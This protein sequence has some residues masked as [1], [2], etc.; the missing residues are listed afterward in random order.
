MN[1]H[2]KTGVVTIPK[3]LD[4]IS[5]NEN[6]QLALAA[7]NLNGKTWDGVIAVFNDAH[8]APNIP[9]IDNGSLNESGCTAIDWID[10]ENIVTSTDAGTIEI[11][12][13]SESLMLE[14][15]VVF[16]EHNDVCSS[17]SVLKQTKH[18]VSGSWDGSIKIWDLQTDAA[19][20]TIMYHAD[21]VLDVTWDTNSVGIFASAS[22]DGTVKVYDNRN[23]G[24]PGCLLLYNQISH[25]T[26]LSWKSSNYV[27]GGFN[28]GEIILLDL[29]YPCSCPLRVIKA[30]RKSINKLISIENLIIS[31]SND[32]SVKMHNDFECV[33]E[34]DRHS[35]YVQDLALQDNTKSVWSCGWDGVLFEHKIYAQAVDF[36]D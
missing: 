32:F 23:E 25:P 29:R 14:N 16:A 17:I 31:A 9:H 10:T 12:K 26:C 20:H 24:K 18:L 21:K 11:W 5:F 3:F 27:F 1:L 22:E 19:L 35:D 36:V 7:S 28:N 34:N 8:F 6:G 33:Y 2:E 30:H 13:K 4:G 15:S